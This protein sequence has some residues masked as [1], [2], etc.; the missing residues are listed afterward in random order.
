VAAGNFVGH[1]KK[2]EENF[3]L[4]IYAIPIGLY[5][6]PASL[7][8]SAAREQAD[9]DGNHRQHQQYMD[10]ATYSLSKSYVAY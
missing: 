3:R 2:P 10:K 8:H 6:S 7:Y 4:Y 9:Q 1:K 5:A